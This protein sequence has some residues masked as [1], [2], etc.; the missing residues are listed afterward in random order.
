MRLD[1]FLKVSRIIKR[2][3]VAK[4]ACEAGVIK[5]NGVKSKP[6]KKLKAGDVVEIETPSF[7]LK[8]EVLSIP[9]TNVKKAEAAS[10][11]RII[12][13]ER[14]RPELWEE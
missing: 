11:V 7:Y 10:L 5:V 12:K 4:E 1:K 3:T 13:E 2:R 8:F 14:R 9:R 6:S